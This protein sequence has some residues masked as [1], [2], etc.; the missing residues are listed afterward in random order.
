M[1]KGR[2]EVVRQPSFRGNASGRLTIGGVGLMAP[3]DRAVEGG[4]WQFIQ[5]GAQE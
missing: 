4:E 1:E 5:Y 2:W 3:R